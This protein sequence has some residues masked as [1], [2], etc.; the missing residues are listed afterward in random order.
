M[1]PAST[2]VLD[3]FGRRSGMANAGHYSFAHQIL[4]VTWRLLPFGRDGHH[5]HGAFRRF[6]PAFEFVY[7]GRPNMFTRMGAPR[8]INRRNMWSLDMEP[9]DGLGLCHFV[10]RKLRFRSREIAQRSQHGRL[11]PGN[12]RRQAAADACREHAAE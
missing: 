3:L 12:H 5:F 1:A 8:A 11:R 10:A 7:I 9:F 2:A 6:L 4:D